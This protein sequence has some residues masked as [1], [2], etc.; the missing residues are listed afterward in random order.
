MA[1]NHD[2]YMRRMSELIAKMRDRTERDR[3]KL[4]KQMGKQEKQ[5]KWRSVGGMAGGIIGAV[6]GGIAGGMG[7]TGVGAVPGAMA[8]FAAGSGVG[9][10]IGSMAAGG[11]FMGPAG[12]GMAAAAPLVKQMM[13]EGSKK[14]PTPKP[15][16]L[17][18]AADI[19]GYT[20]P[21]RTGVMSHQP[22]PGSVMM[23]PTLTGSAAMGPPII[24]D[25][26][27]PRRY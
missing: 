17:V 6:G 9:A 12:Q 8:G 27:M 23:G 14:P 19:Q 20:L 3:G 4:E 26:L 2:E 11:D 7:G 13:R 21:Q 22:P 25:H 18:N 5:S 24:P 15:G 16:E 10:G 1:S